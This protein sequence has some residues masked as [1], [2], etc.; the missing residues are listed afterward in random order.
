[1]VFLSFATILIPIQSIPKNICLTI[2]HIKTKLSTSFTFTN[3]KVVIRMQKLNDNPTLHEVQTLI[4][5]SFK[6]KKLITLALTHS[7]FKNEQL[8]DPSSNTC[9]D[10]ER[11][12]FLGDTV[13]SFVISKELFNTFSDYPEGKLSKFR[14]ILVSK[15]HLFKV[16]KELK[17]L[18]FLR[19]GKSEQQGQIK[20]K[21]N[22]MADSLEALIA[23]I[24]LDGGLKNAEKFILKN[25]RKYI[26]NKRLAL[27]DR[28]YKSML[29]EYAQKEYKVLPQYITLFKGNQFEA[30]VVIAKSKKAK[31]T[32]K[33]KREAEQGAAQMLL[34]SLK[35]KNKKK[36]RV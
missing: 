9:D 23:A 2:F 7:S 8:N 32:G 6:N 31:G 29:Q 27:L 26:S 13:L 33:S 10:N 16:A 20:D 21:G 36:K 34:R 35:M 22:I 1:M 15:N 5:Y 4:D 14:S 25:F 24:Y 19:L 3:Y 28:N 12:E 18:R 11:L 17:L 30:T